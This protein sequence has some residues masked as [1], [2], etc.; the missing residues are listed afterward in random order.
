M[1]YLGT[2]SFIWRVDEHNGLQNIAFVVK[3]S[4][5]WKENRK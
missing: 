5:A 3:N 2:D 4:L 1:F